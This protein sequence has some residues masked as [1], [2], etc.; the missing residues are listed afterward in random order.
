MSFGRERD[1]TAPAQ[2]VRRAGAQ[3]AAAPYAAEGQTVGAVDSS[4]VCRRGTNCGSS[5]QQLR[6]PP[7]DKLRAQP[8]AAPYA[9]APWSTMCAVCGHLYGV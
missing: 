9:A 8:A 3:P 4:S 1:L 5:L 7:R 2:T 6:M